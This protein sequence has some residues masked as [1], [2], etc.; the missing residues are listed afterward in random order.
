MIKLG[1][2][3]ACNEALFQFGSALSSFVLA[4]YFNWKLALV[5]TSIVLLLLVF[6]GIFGT[7]V[8]CI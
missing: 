3:S 5:A 4:L 6:L 8:T 2:S 7:V 1:I